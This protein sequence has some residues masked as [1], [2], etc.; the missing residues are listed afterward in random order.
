MKK[1]LQTLEFSFEADCLTHYG[2][3]FLIQRFCHKLDLH[4]RLQRHW[5]DQPAGTGFEPVAVVEVLLFLLIAGVQRLNKSDKLQYDG[6][7][8]ALLGLEK[9]PDQS[10]LRRFLQ[11]LSPAAIRQLVQ[12][13]DQLRRDLFARPQARSSLIFY[14]DS[15]VLTLHGRQQGA[16]V[17]YNPKAKGRPSYHPLLCFEGHGQEFWHGSLRP[18]DAG[19]NTGARH[20][21]RR[22]LA[23][24]PP[25]VPRSRIRFLADAGF[26]SG[27][28]L[29]DLDQWG[30]GFT[31]VGRS[32]E[33]YKN[34][35]EKAGF[36]NLKL[37]WGFAEFEHRPQKWTQAR[38][39]VAIRRPLPI[40]PD[41]ATQLTLFKD[42]HYSYSILV[43]NLGL[44]PWR[45]WT[46]YLDRA[47]IER[48]IRE[49]LADLALN[50][51]PTQ[52][53]TANVA[54]FQLLLFAYDLV[55][56]FKRLCLPAAQL[57][58]TLETLRHEL[59]AIPGKLT[60]RSGR[61]VLVLPRQYDHQNEFLAAAKTVANLPT[62]K[63]R[64]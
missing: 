2:G 12:A 28:L 7:F 51:I 47:N 4:Q 62:L 55:H 10:S 35:A 52:S 24:V 56:W 50:K 9:L 16:R 21:V 26:F 15:V 11:R 44:T 22:C 59:L 46:D 33:H 30:C 13:H 20:F 32:Y 18:G 17:G 39:F 58:T 25:T 43:S 37:G 54:F 63:L 57:G 5:Y 23:K 3:L 38:R 48:S 45:T 29:D 64:Q 42:R 6:F 1:G 14:L 27:G 34:L 60:C 41:L 36:Q 31:I 53:W 49:L 19:S 40:D 61:N 8:L